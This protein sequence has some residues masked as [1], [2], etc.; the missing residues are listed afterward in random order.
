MSRL[1]DTGTELA[2]LVGGAAVLIAI[3]L[4]L[5]FPRPS[6]KTGWKK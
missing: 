5:I 6:H 3:G 4:A 1:A 2:A